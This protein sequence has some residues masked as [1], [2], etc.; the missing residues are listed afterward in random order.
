MIRQRKIAMKPAMTVREY[1]RTRI[2][3]VQQERNLK[4]QPPKPKREKI[5]PIAQ[6]ELFS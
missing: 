2:R 3:D 1:V 4:P 6:K 5:V